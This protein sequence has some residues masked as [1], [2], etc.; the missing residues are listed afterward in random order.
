MDW[1]GL[2]RYYYRAA[3]LAFC[4]YGAIMTRILAA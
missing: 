2:L 4:P 3:A 1:K